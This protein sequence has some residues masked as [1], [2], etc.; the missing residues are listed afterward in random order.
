[1]KLVIQETQ[2]DLFVRADLLPAKAP[3][4]VAFLAAYLAGPR[5]VP[6][7]HAMWTGPEISCPIPPQHLAADQPPLPQENATLHPEAGDVVLAYV[8]P[9]MWGGNPDPIF[10]IGLFYGPG[11][12]MFF[13]IGWLAGSVVAKVLPDDRARL[14]EACGKIRRNGACTIR[15]ALET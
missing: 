15:F 14:A 5:D 10:D 12:R 11:A 2:S 6:G 4:N 9:R 1:M 7:L 13:P 8:P 3:A